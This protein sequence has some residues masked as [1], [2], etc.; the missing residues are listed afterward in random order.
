MKL[1]EYSKNGKM[2]IDMLEDG[3]IF[4]DRDP[5]KFYYLLEYLRTS[6]LNNKYKDHFSKKIMKEEF[7]YY[8]IVW[9]YSFEK[10]IY[11][12]KF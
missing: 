4:I 6:K 3:S 11:L 8:S 5:K 7:E 1:V 9:P 12:S 10:E 2:T